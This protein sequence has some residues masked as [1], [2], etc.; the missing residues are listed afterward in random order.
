M[1]SSHSDL[2]HFHGGILCAALSAAYASQAL[3]GN[4]S[5]A[6]TDGLI[7]VATTKGR[8]VRAKS[9]LPVPE[10]SAL[11]LGFLAISSAVVDLRR[12]MMA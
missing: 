8:A 11:I 6:A 4:G 3:L 7:S 12:R 1:V 5:K 9:D 2:A 10:P